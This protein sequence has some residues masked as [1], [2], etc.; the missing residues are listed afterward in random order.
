MKD[1]I[2]GGRDIRERIHQVLQ[3]LW[4]EKTSGTDE[5]MSPA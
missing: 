4:K 1:V 2:R 5:E 3:T